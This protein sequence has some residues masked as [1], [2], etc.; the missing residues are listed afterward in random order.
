MTWDTANP[1]SSSPQEF[2]TPKSEIDGDTTESKDNLNPE[3]DAELASHVHHLSPNPHL[4][5][6]PV[7]PS[8]QLSS[9]P[10]PGSAKRTCLDVL[11]VQKGKRD[12]ESSSRKT[13]SG[14]PSKRR[15]L[16]KNTIRTTPPPMADQRDKM[17]SASSTSRMGPPET[18]GRQVAASPQFFP[19][20]RFSPDL[21]QTPRSG[22]I[23]VPAIPHNRLFW[24]PS[25]NP[26]DLSFQDP[27]GPPHQDLVSPITPSSVSSHGFQSAAPVSSAN[28]YDLPK[29]QSTRT[30]G[31]PLSSSIDD[32]P[33]PILFTAS[34]R[35]IV[36]VPEDPSMFLSS[37]ARR[38]GSANQPMCSSSSG[39]R[40]ELQ[41][42]HHQLQE[43]KR[44][45]EFQ[46]AK[47]ITTKKLSTARDPKNVLKR[48]VSPAPNNR[49]GF[50]RSSTYSGVGDPY[51]VQRRQSQ[52]SFAESVSVLHDGNR[53][54]CG[55]PSSL[56]KTSATNTH[57]DLEQPRSRSRTSLSFTI[58]KDGRAKTVVTR[59]SDRPA[60]LSEIEDDSSD[61]ETDSLGAA[62]FDIVRSQNNSFAFTEQEEQHR[63]IARLR[64]ES[65]SHSKSSS[66]SS[67]MGSSAS[68]V[69]SS[70]TSSAAG[71]TRPWSRRP[72]DRYA[73]NVLA[74]QTRRNFT[75]L[76]AQARRDEDMTL[77]DDNDESG[78]AQHA[79]RAIL[80]DRPRPVSSNI[81]PFSTSQ[82]DTSQ[83]FHSSPPIPP[84]HRY[85]IY[86]ASPTTI[87]DPDLA[88]PSTDRGSHASNASTR[89]VCN[90]SS[91]DGKPMIQWY[92]SPTLFLSGPS[93][94]LIRT[95]TRSPSSESCSKWLHA[96][97]V[98]VESHQVP[99][100]YICAFCAQ[101]PM[102]HGRVR[103]PSRA[104]A[105]APASPLAHKKGRYQR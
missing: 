56:L 67:T 2:T 91:P 23:T 12:L 21:L 63:P 15:L 65:K 13:S 3:I 49:A 4:T 72:E 71:G 27:F 64:H 40:P 96:T 101:T 20:L 104:A 102:R 8:R 26:E 75:A 92:A 53:H 19:N 77:E 45:E 43:S 22:P 76:P 95:L 48:P 58:D 37:P 68:A 28:V 83:Q 6:P 46:R 99:P 82:I 79:L 66:Y 98:G 11:Y 97:C 105:M 33:F 78:G 30:L 47:K 42:Y 88:T 7:E 34:P 54:L 52:V 85:G 50:K 51:P 38:F 57:R 17:M 60:S 103:E 10:G 25:S 93:F 89:C 81:A 9:S 55:R 73:E 35:V 59:I 5:L 87:T 80:K 36:S 44:E 18:P 94:K 90:S 29:S 39:N 70:R 84:H 1:C 31:P 100:I 61:S 16:D 86:N 24:D 41:A 62:D 74:A 14:S 32:S 69:P